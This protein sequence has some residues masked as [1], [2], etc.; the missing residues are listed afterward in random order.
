MVPETTGNVHVMP[1]V[2]EVDGRPLAKVSGGQ[3]TAQWK[4]ERS[5]WLNS[6]GGLLHRADSNTATHQNEQVAP[7]K[8]NLL[9]LDSCPEA[10]TPPASFAW[11]H[12]ITNPTVPGTYFH[13]WS[14]YLSC[15]S[16]MLHV[17]MGV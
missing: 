11:R 13:K 6:T 10:C 4:G 16:D 2:S 9:E 1:L 14:L 3:P 5:A 12:N 7:R 15:S 8:V 17:T